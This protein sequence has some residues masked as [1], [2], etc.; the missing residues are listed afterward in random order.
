MNIKENITV[1]SRTWT[2][3]K[4]QDF[5]TNLEKNDVF[6]FSSAFSMDE[7]IMIARSNG[8]RVRPLPKNHPHY[9]KYGKWMLKVSSIQSTCC[10]DFEY[11]NFVENLKVEKIKNKDLCDLCKHVISKG[12][13]ALVFYP[14]KDIKRNIDKKYYCVRCGYNSL[15]RSIENILIL[16][17]LLS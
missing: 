5:F 12:E 1:I 10:S 6:G 14:S 2:S 8:V 15:N 16:L 7:I 9:K 13:K 3:I 4:I 11:R 17:K